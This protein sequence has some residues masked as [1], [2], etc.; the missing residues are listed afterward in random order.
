MFKQFNFMNSMSVNFKKNRI[1]LNQ[2]QN[3]L[4]RNRDFK[5]I[6]FKEIKFV[7]TKL[8]FEFLKIVLTKTFK[9]K[10][11]FKKKFSTIV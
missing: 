6:S 7:K 1:I 10:L 8:V 2:L 5:L 3:F 9:R 11:T 4:K